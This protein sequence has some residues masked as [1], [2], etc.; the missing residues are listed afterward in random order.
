[1][2][3]KKLLFITFAIVAMLSMIVAACGTNPKKEG[4]DDNDATQIESVKKII[5]KIDNAE[6]GHSSA[7][8]SAKSTVSALSAY[9]MDTGSDENEISTIEDVELLLNE[10]SGIRSLTYWLVNYTISDLLYYVCD[11]VGDDALNYIYKI[12]YEGYFTPMSTIMVPIYSV[13]VKG[14][15]NG[16]MYGIVE[17][18]KDGFAYQNYVVC[19]L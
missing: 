2:K 18:K 17:S 15:Y 7:P 6:Y 4:G 10:D 14:L 3:K 11:T 13:D 1:M 9:A 5:T 16:V 12:D 19:V 8:V